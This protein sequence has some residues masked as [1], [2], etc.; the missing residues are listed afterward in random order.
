ME[1]QLHQCNALTALAAQAASLYSTRPLPLLR[2]LF[3]VQME[4]LTTS[5]TLDAQV[6]NS[7]AVVLKARFPTKITVSLAAGPS[8]M[9]AIKLLGRWAR[10]LQ[11]NAQD[12]T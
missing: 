2:P 7:S 11:A 8:S 10:T 9:A 5:P 1:E 4:E 3:V 12:L 6:F